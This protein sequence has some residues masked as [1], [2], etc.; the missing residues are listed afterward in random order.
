[1]RR[2]VETADERYYRRVVQPQRARTRRWTAR[3]RARVS[4]PEHGE[5]VVPCGSTLEA[6]MCA[7]EVW[8]V[9]WSKVL[10]AEVWAVI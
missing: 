2:N 6:V 5:V 8:G 9:D 10:G 7:A 1:M 4:H 3:G